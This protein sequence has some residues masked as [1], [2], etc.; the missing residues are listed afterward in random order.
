E[1]DAKAFLVDEAMMTC[2]EQQK[3]VEPSLPAVRP[4]F[5]MASVEKG[6]MR[7][8]GKAAL[9]AA[10]LERPTDR[11]RD[12]AF[13]AADAHRLAVFAVRDEVCRA[14]AREPTCS[15]RRDRLAALELT[16]SA[17][18]FRVCAGRVFAAAR[19]HARV[20]IDH[21]LHASA[22]VSGGFTVRNEA[23]GDAHQ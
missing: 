23:L 18:P 19:E 15:L 17:V 11:G 16:L 4:V 3:I 8:T 14:I 2:A 22:R 7:A 20:D 10:R 9:V 1:L 12:S 5:D 13:L 6:A 21:D